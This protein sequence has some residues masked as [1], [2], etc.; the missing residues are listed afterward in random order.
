M[1][2]L[3]RSA[4]FVCVALAACSFDRN[5]LPAA[6]DA[7]QVQTPDGAPD[8]APGAPDARPADATVDATVDARPDAMCA[9]L[10][11]T[12][13]NV[14]PCSI[15]PSGGDLTITTGSWKFN[16][17]TLVL[18][19]N[20]NQPVTI[21]AATV[22][23]S[24]GGQMVAVI[25]AGT[26]T[27]DAGAT[28][29]LTG[30]RPVVLVG[31]T[32][33]QID[34][35]A[36]MPASYGVIDASGSGHTSG[37]GAGTDADCT[38]VDP[39]D[40][41]GADGAAYVDDKN[42]TGG[43]GGGGGGFGAAGGAGGINQAGVGATDAPGGLANGDA[44]IAPLRGGCHGGAGGNGG[45]Q[46]GGAGGAL[47]IITPMLTVNGEI[48]AAG[49]GGTGASA[50]SNS[51]GGGGGGAGGALL[52]DAPSITIGS[53]ARF[54]ANGGGGGEGHRNSLAG[55]GNGATGHKTDANPAAGGTSA[56][57]DGGPGGAGGALASGAVD[58]MDGPRTDFNAGGAGG[59]GGAVGRIHFRAT[60]ITTGTV[61]LSPAPQ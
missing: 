22:P 53:A 23:Q 43:S 32:A 48:T 61:V 7:P 39:K 31:A 36:G 17:S 8:S 28:L 56:F 41:Y 50:S 16:S 46:G 6:S 34:E 29:F 18:T 35:M 54:T 44:Q 45:G 51:A 24:G 15:P 58:G 40:G 10:G 12:P 19:D 42:N 30:T 9:M 26:I 5:G 60:V 4:G 11:F 27:V 57:P 21:S 52:L 38:S 55:G 59:G 47:Q 1:G 37:P 3:R 33:V 49:G 25:S 13:A 14:D 20:N 2:S